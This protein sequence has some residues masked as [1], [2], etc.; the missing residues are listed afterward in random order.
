M[1][2]PLEVF[3]DN[4][5]IE[6]KTFLDLKNFRQGLPVGGGISCMLLGEHEGGNGVRGDMVQHPRGS[7]YPVI[8]GVGTI[9]RRK[10]PGGKR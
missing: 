4:A 3:S 5:N 7:L 2:P 8:Y 9:G 1:S 6:S 10:D